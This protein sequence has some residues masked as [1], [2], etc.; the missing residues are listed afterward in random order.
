VTTTH[1]S[2]GPMRQYYV[3]EAAFGLP[4]APF[5]DRTLH[6]LSAALPGAEDPLTLE[7]RRVPMGPNVSLRQRVDEAIETEASKGDGFA[8]IDLVEAALDGAPALL[9]RARRRKHD[10]VTVELQAHV[11]LGDTW[12]SFV[13][14]GPAS[15]RKSCEATFDRLVHGLR[16]RRR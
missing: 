11:A 1:P 8:V 7:I 16:W 6:R 3:N 10:D 2:L 4:E 14:A 13:V 9:L 15:H 12:L 5:V